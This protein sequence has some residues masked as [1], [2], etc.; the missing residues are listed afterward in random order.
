MWRDVSYHNTIC[1]DDHVVSDC[2]AAYNLAAC[3]QAN[4]IA[5]AR[6]PFAASVR[7]IDETYAGVDGAVITDYNSVG[8]DDS[9]TGVNVKSAT[10][11]GAWVNVGAAGTTN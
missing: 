6:H 9:K 10:N 3:A 11:H 1:A 4:V 5:N 2:D 8:D 7:F